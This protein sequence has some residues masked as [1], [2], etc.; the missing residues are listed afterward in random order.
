MYRPAYSNPYPHCVYYPTSAETYNSIMKK[1]RRLERKAAQDPAFAS[2][3]NRDYD[4]DDDD[5]DDDYDDDDEAQQ[6]QQVASAP[7]G[8]VGRVST[9]AAR[10]GGAGPGA[11]ANAGRRF[12]KNKGK[13]RLTGAGSRRTT[14]M[15]DDRPPTADEGQRMPTNSGAP[16]GGGRGVAAGGG[17]GKRMIA[18]PARSDQGRST[19]PGIGSTPLSLLDNIVG[20][21]MAE[22]SS[23]SGSA[24]NKA[25]IDADNCYISSPPSIAIP[26]P[27]SEI[28]P[29]DMITAPS[30]PPSSS[31]TEISS[32]P[33]IPD[34][35]PNSRSESIMSSPQPEPASLS[36]GVAE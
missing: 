4:D 6:Q 2:A 17:N 34:Q 14:A 19:P 3:D 1:I 35:V 10:G 15:T 23:T 24:A 12:S 8:N 29:Q 21:L 36:L 32:P 28:T 5:Y 11:G 27:P 30:L 26:L 33:E 25:I 22:E 20:N 31:P 16:S 18:M 9:L 13:L 7:T